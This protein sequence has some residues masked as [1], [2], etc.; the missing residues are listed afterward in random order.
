MAVVFLGRLAVAEHHAG[1]HRICALDVGVVET[2][3]VPGLCRESE[4]GLHPLHKFV[5]TGIRVVAL[6][7]V[8]I[9]YPRLARVAFRHLK[10][11]TLVAAAGD[12]KGHS[13]HF[14][15]GLFGDH[16][17]VIFYAERGLDFVHGVC[18]QVCPTLV[19]ATFVAQCHGPHHSTVAY[20]HVV[21][22]CVRAGFVVDAEDVQLVNGLGDYHGPRPIVGDDVVFLFQLLGFLKPQIR[23]ITLHLVTQICHELRYFT[24]QYLLYAVDIHTVLLRGNKA[25]AAS[26]AALYMVIQTQASFVAGYIVGCYRQ[27]ACPHRIQLGD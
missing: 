7:P 2:F 9:V 16:N 19:K 18:Q 20:V 5:C 27:A 17:L 24:S 25:F 4:I 10:E 8:Q 13:G 21:N 6:Q 15:G 23:R 11:L 26:F 1:G 14:H 12:G 3:Y 22:I